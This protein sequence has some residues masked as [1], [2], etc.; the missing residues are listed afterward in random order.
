MGN[1]QIED[2]N[3]IYGKIPPQAIEVEEAV[4]GALMLE[5]EAY[6]RISTILKTESFYK[7]EHKKIFEVIKWLADNERAIDLLQVTQRIKDISQFEE[8]GG[9]EYITRLTNKVAAAT[10]IEYHARIIE[11]KFIQREIIRISHEASNKAYDESIDVSD[12]INWASIQY[13]NIQSS[14]SSLIKTT[15]DLIPEIYNK[16]KENLELKRNT[17]GFPT[18]IQPYDE[19]T[20]GLQLT[21][22]TIIAADSGQGKTSLLITFINNITKTNTPFSI[23][24]LE[25]IGMQIITRVISQETNIPGKRI[26]NKKLENHEIAQIDDVIEET[27]QKKIFIDE[28]SNKTLDSIL[29]NIR[30]LYIKYGIQLFGIDYIQLISVSNNKIIREEKLALIARSL[31]N[32]CKELNIHILALSQLSRDSTSTNKRPTM[33]RL[34]GSG[35]IEEAADNIILIYRPEEFGI[36]YFDNEEPAQGKAELILAKGRNVG[37]SSFIIRFNKETGRFFHE[38]LDYINDPVEQ[39]LFNNPDAFIESNK[40]NEEKPF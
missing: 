18:G 39:N 8:I 3:A 29:S 6:G 34:R 17:T 24:S 30:Y 22:L 4:L 28:S 33:S 13:G 7:E 16:I 5:A 26:L 23:M 9:P 38:S 25:M 12:V 1:K 21:D 27:K 37:T 20:G 35:Q 15:E 36:D 31:K 19:F 10:N 14:P 2:I 32:I 40:E 11:Q